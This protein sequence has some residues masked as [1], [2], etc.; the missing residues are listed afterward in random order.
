[1]SGQTIK[2]GRNDPCPCGSGRKYKHCCMAAASADERAARSETMSVRQT[3]GAALA[4]HQAGRLR[5]ADALY[6]QVLQLQPSN[7]DALHL[8]GMIA[9]QT[10]EHETAV[11][12]I[13]RAISA[14]P[15]NPA[16]HSNLAWALHGQGKLAEAVASFRKALTLAPGDAGVHANLGLVLQNQGRLDEAVASFR[17][18]IKLRPTLAEAHTNLGSALHVQGRLDEAIA[19]HRAALS[20]KPD[21]AAAHSNLGNALRGQ[22]KLEEAAASLREAIK[23]KP[24]YSEAH[25]NLGLA[26]QH[27]G[28]LDEALASHREAIR[29]KPDDAAPQNHLA[30]GLQ[31]QGRLDEAVAGFRKAL[32]LRPDYA[33]AHSNLGLA[34]QEQGKLNEAAA[35][36]R[37]AIRLKPD[38]ADAHYNRHS[39]L[40][41]QD[42]LVPA[43]E[44][45]K[46]AVAIDPSKT[47]YRFFLGMLLDYAGD[48]AAAADHFDRVESGDAL[49][50]ARLDAWRYVKSASP[51]PLPITGSAIQSFRL[52]L[53]AAPSAGMVLE[54]GVRFGTSI[55]QIAALVNQEVHGF[56]SFEGLPEAWHHEPQ[57]SYSTSGIIPTVPGNVILHAGWF[58]DTL[59]VFL[60]E[61]AGPVRFANI[62]CDIYSSTRTV[63]RFL[64]QRIVPGTVIVFDEYIGNEHWREDEFKAFQEAVVENGWNYEYLCFSFFTKQVVIRILGG[65]G[66][67]QDGLAA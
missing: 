12:L 4:H 55:R 24:D 45:M 27:L 60:N 44:S 43:I 29:F 38:L 14:S 34:F 13:N 39:L 37:E 1:M 10:G 31:G 18:A 8:L 64:A 63:L 48:H 21:L 46:R 33:E 15:S 67:P 65:S 57:G 5:E 54:F 66:T 11:A 47:N 28:K 51:K 22:G 36:Y 2:T 42:D 30:L 6:R 25:D 16:F 9:C 7:P 3:L 56:D 59:P 50:R 20:L 40:L 49:Y 32:L 61:H 23:F 52:G 19:S 58:E 17:E 41:D 35:S 26:L 53:D 62:D